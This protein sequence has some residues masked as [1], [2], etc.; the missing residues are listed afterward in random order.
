MIRSLLILLFCVF[1]LYIIFTKILD[2]NTDFITPIA[3]TFS[4]VMVFLLIFMGLSGLSLIY[5]AIDSTPVVSL[6]PEGIHV[7]TYIFFK[8]YIPWEEV[9][10]VNQEI[11]KQR[12]NMIDVG[13]S[14]T[15]FRIHRA[16]KR[17]VAI[18]L[19]MLKR[20]KEFETTLF[21]Y[22]EQLNQQIS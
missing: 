6:T 12:V 13:L 5:K 7:K 3:I 16:N 1:G 18:N 10:L 8:Q 11:Y 15:M 20:G 19:S 2:G 22:I 14:T 21:D 17:S 4:W 9:L